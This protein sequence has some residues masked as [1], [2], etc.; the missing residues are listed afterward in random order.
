MIYSLKHS[1]DES[2]CKARLVKVLSSVKVN[3]L[4]LYKCAENEQDTKCAL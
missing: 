3:L 2:M 4:L 1:L